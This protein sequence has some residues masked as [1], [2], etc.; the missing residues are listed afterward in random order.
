M[1]SSSNKNGTSS[2]REKYPY[3]TEFNVLD[4]VP[5]LLSERNYENWK[6]LMR[7]FIRM[8]GL[9]GFIEGA[10][11]KD[12]NRDEAWERSN[13][14]VRGW[15]LVTLSEDIRPGVLSSESAK[16]VWTRLEEIFDPTRSKWQP[17]EEMEYRQG[18]YLA[19]QKA[20]INGNWDKASEIIEREPDAVRTHITPT[21][22]TALH[23]A[24]SS[25]SKGRK[26]FMTKLL[27]TMTPQDVVG[28]VN[29]QGMTALHYAAVVDYE[30]GARML[31]NKNSDLPNRSAISTYL[32]IHLA[33]EYGF[34]DMV[35]YLMEVHAAYGNILLRDDDAGAGLLFLLTRS[36][37]YDIALTLL[38]QKPKLACMEPNPFDIIVEKHSSFPSGNSS[39][40]WHNLVY[41]G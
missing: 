15:I 30:E 17:D 14:L 20:A 25:G 28:L 33:A 2:P 23:L 3:P 37:M 39:N 9:I 6:L 8:R 29:L 41:L 38:E 36:E 1:A 4:F 21:L 34:R 24:V 40:F 13:N 26:D 31:V 10:A 27:E 12:S 22:Q 7:D 18:H 16:G 5:K 19:L 11:A 32:P 35:R